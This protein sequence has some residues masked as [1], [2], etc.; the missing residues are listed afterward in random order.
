M[1][2][3]PLSSST[4]VETPVIQKRT[5]TPKQNTGVSLNAKIGLAS[6]GVFSCLMSYLALRDNTPLPNPPPSSTSIASE[7]ATGIFLGIF[8]LVAGWKM[9]DS[10]AS[11][12]K[13]IKPT[14]NEK[15]INK[16]KLNLKE[17]TD[18]FETQKESLQEWWRLSGDYNN[19]LCPTMPD[20]SPSELGTLYQIFK[21]IENEF[22]TNCNEMF[23]PLLI[24]SKL[25]SKNSLVVNFENIS[26]WEP[27]LPVDQHVF[28]RFFGGFILSLKTLFFA[29]QS[30]AQ[31]SRAEFLILPNNNFKI[32]FR[33][34]NPY[35]HVLFTREGKI[36]KPFNTEWKIGKDDICRMVR[37]KEKPQEKEVV[38]STSNIQTTSISTKQLW[39]TESIIDD[40]ILTNNNNDPLLIK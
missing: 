12:E 35:S 32:S 23:R 21:S 20:L 37:E 8:T 26:K 31:G 2:L 11:E 33:D 39:E 6:L 24:Y 16:I 36:D 1:Q 9:K 5:Q 17:T 7:I 19:H 29:F 13:Q 15:S 27:K 30:D 22:N 38:E 3:K 34:L 40:G 4:V 28:K 14:S 10:C 25:E 18:T